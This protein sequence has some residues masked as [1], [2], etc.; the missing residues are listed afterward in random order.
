[1][2]ESQISEKRPEKYLLVDEPYVRIF[3]LI[4][5]SNELYSP[6]KLNEMLLVNL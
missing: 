3:T 2:T 5:Q 4:K 6:N 1:M